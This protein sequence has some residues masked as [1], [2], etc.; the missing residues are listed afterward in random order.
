M[1]FNANSVFLYFTKTNSQSCPVYLIWEKAKTN[2][3]FLVSL[4]K[5]NNNYI[6]Q[7]WFEK[8]SLFINNRT[9]TPSKVIVLSFKD[10]DYPLLEAIDSNRIPSGW[11]DTNFSNTLA[12]FF[13]PEGGRLIN[14]GGWKKVFK[15]YLFFE[16][17]FDFLV[18]LPC[19]EKE[20]EKIFSKLFD[21][22][23]KFNDPQKL[24]E[25]F[26]RIFNE[27]LERASNQP[28]LSPD[29]FELIYR[30]NINQLNL[31]YLQGT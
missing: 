16:D 15:S 28:K 24:K 4:I 21:S 9:K 18:G 1:I 6:L 22:I 23:S 10:P 27:A 30:L 13:V 7:S 25:E 20:R 14:D 2:S 11:F 31:N 3:N 26:A 8:Y 17:K 12:V 5:K 29:L 19:F